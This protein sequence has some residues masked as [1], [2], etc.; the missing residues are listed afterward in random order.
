MQNGNNT[1]SL[2]QRNL[3]SLETDHRGLSDLW[4]KTVKIICW[5]LMNSFS[6][7]E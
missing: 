2:R 4:F 7:E 5:T 6:V 3:A 1:A